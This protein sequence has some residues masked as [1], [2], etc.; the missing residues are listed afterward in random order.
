[1]KLKLFYQ[2]KDGDN[3]KKAKGA[4]TVTSISQDP[5]TILASNTWMKED[6]EI[7]FDSNLV[8]KV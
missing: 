2:N 3:S 5:L 8:T 4:L 6:K 1:M 7:E